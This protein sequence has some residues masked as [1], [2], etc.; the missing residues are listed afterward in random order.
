MSMCAGA[1]RG[2]RGGRQKQS[3]QFEGVL[4]I[5]SRHHLLC[6]PLPQ[7][8]DCRQTFGGQLEGLIGLTRALRQR[9]RT[10]TRTNAKNQPREVGEACRAR[11][12]G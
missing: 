8:R 4:D 1:E 5:E 3:L 11:C 9:Q 6:Q 10:R 2:G 7:I 12:E